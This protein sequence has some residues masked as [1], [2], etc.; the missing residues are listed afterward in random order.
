MSHEQIAGQKSQ[1]QAVSESFENVANFGYLGATLRNQD[2]IYTK[3]KSRLSS[4]NACY[5]SFE[6][7]LSS[8]LLSKI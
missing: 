5:H 1:H 8:G 7:L 6:I 4:G 2:Y 3:I